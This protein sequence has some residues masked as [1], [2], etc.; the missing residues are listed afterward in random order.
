M[1]LFFSPPVLG[2]FPASWSFGLSFPDLPALSTFF[3]PWWSFWFFSNC[4]ACMPGE[5]AV[6]SSPVLSY[7]RRWF[8]KKAQKKNRQ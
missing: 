7:V 3:F 1:G 4:L 6:D 8:L 2:L 5:N